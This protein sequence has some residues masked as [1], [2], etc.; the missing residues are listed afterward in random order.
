MKEEVADAAIIGGS[1]AG[2]SAAMALGRSVRNTLVFDD[3][4]PCNR[5]TPHA[6]N[7]LTLDGE[8][9]GAIREKA[10]RQVDAYPTVRR[11]GSRITGIERHEAFFTLQNQAGETWKA[12]KLILATGVRDLLPEIPGFAETWGKTVVHC[13]YCH[14]YELRGQK[15]ALM[16]NG[17]MAFHLIKVLA[18]LAQ[19]LT[20]VTNGP[21]A[22]TAEQTAALSAKNIA[23]IEKE[24]VHLDQHEGYIRRVHFADGELLDL[25]VL[26]AKIP[27]AQS[28]SIPATLGLDFDEH[29]FVKVNDFQATSVPGIYAAGDMTSMGRSV[30]M[31]MAAGIRAGV[32]VNNELSGEAFEKAGNL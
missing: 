19:D 1:Y 14:G 10:I 20:L 9:P 7:I 8:A 13:P 21:S 31:A 26:Y 23:V 25:S 2:L 24:I 4:K 5:F 30:V 11:I 18:N 16:A 15:T 3:D 17:E 28:S 12:K 6:H 32:S 29:G 22:L 27:F